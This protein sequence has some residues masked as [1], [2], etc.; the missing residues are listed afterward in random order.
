M[1]SHDNRRAVITGAGSGIGRG[2]AH[3]LAADG[4]AVAVLDVDGA[5]SRRPAARPWR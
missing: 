5:R 1:P 2:I 4:A 3:R